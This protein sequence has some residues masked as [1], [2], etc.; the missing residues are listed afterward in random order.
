M[1]RLKNGRVHATVFLLI[2]WFQELLERNENNSL[3]K[4]E[5]FSNHV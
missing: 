1:I 4:F 2:K 5:S 3:I